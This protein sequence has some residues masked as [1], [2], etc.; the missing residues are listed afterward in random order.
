MSFW[1]RYKF[2]DKPKP[3]PSLIETLTE[4]TKR[5]EAENKALKVE[6]ASL[7]AALGGDLSVAV[8][9]EIDRL[10][11]SLRDAY[12][13]L[14]AAGLSVNLLTDTLWELCKVPGI[15]IEY[16]LKANDICTVTALVSPD[17]LDEV[18]NALSKHGMRLMG[19]PIS[20]GDRVACAFASAKGV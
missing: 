11:E 15:R 10:R 20:V 16:T 19:E 9:A 2:Q 4:I 8:N 5:L 7:K 12:D 13:R 14:Q 6:N 3:E 1:D 17:R 18:V